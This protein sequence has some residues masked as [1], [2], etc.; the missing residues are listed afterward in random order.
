MVLA[1]PT[2]GRPGSPPGYS[3]GCVVVQDTGQEPRQLVAL[4]RRERGEQLV[5][6]PCQYPVEPPELPEPG[7]GDRDDV[8]SAAVVSTRTIYQN[9]LARPTNCVMLVTPTLARPT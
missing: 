8:A 1:V 2:C 4:V 6:D 7:R 9:L 3:A 5:L